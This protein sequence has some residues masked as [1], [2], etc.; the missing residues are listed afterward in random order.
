MVVSNI[1]VHSSEP[2][3]AGNEAH[4]SWINLCL[5]EDVLLKFTFKH[6]IKA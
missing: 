6:Y 2:D 5:I 4:L 1:D 3:T